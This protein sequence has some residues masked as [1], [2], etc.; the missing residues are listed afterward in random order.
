MIINVMKNLTLLLL[1]VVSSNVFAEWTKVGSYSR[2]FG[3]SGLTI[4]STGYIDFGTIKKKG[5]KVTMWSL[6]D[7]ETA[8]VS[9][10]IIHYEYDCK[11]R[12]IKELQ[13][14]W[15]SGNMGSG[16]VKSEDLATSER[17][18]RP[19]DPTTLDDKFFNNACSNVPKNVSAL[20]LEEQ[21][22]QQNT[23]ESIVINKSK[24][25]M[26]DTVYLFCSNINKRDIVRDIFF[27]N[28]N[29]ITDTMHKLRDAYYSK[30]YVLFGNILK[31]SDE[32]KMQVYVPYTKNNNVITWR[33]LDAFSNSLY[34]TN[35]YH[36]DTNK[37]YWTACQNNECLP[38]VTFQCEIK[39]EKKDIQ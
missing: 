19:I 7:D 30:D 1:L 17:K 20:T 34:E 16:D 36:V 32:I 21:A 18:S 26:D 11:E 23:S 37:F 12:T 9:S 25:V 2:P 35:E 6:I 39:S 5:N 3:F 29:V 33:S 28:G 10:A 14:V 27:N 24:L 31:Y 8:E 13:S 22:N 4:I 38:I 15:Y